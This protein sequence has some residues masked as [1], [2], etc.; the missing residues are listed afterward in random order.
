MTTVL[1]LNYQLLPA[2]LKT[3]G[4]T[5]LFAGKWHLASGHFYPIFDMKGGLFLFCRDMSDSG[6]RTTR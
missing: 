3:R 1:P 4:Y 2:V 5:T 6:V